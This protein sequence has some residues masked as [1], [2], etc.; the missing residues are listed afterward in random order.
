MNNECN[1]CRLG[2]RPLRFHH[3]AILSS[4]RTSRSASKSVF[5]S[6]N[7]RLKEQGNRTKRG[8]GG[9][10]YSTFI[11]NKIGGILHCP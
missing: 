3:F 7:S 4:T 10:S 5:C 6:E 1:P 9:N 8:S 11:Q 2:C